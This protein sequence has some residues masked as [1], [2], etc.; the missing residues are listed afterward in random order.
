MELIYVH[1]VLVLSILNETGFNIISDQINRLLQSKMLNIINLQEYFTLP[2]GEIDI[3]TLEKIISLTEKKI[4]KKSEK[5]ISF[6]FIYVSM[7]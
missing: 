7:S 6:I 4:I 5:V 2:N 1:Q 3:L